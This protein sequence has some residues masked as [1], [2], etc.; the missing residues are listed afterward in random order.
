MANRVLL[1]NHSS[2][3]YGLFISKP[4]VN[5][6]G[7]NKLTNIFDTQSDVARIGQVLL[8][9][10]LDVP[11]SGLTFT[12]ANFNCNTYSYVISDSSHG[13]INYSTIA[14]SSSYVTVSATQTNS[15]TT[16]ATFSNAHTSAVS[17]VYLVVKEDL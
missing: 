16:T 14:V 11:A 5:V 17:C 13:A 15:T 10:E 7:A 2:Y 8:F 9:Q 12:H 3:G 1:G 6:L 4:G